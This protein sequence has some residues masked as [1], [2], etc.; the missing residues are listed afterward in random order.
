MSATTTDTPKLGIAIDYDGWRRLLRE[1]I[2]EVA[3]PDADFKVTME[4]TVET[5]LQRLKKKREAAEADDNNILTFRIEKGAG[6]GH[7]KE[8]GKI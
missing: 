7:Q 6:N 2:D 1:F 8:S 5:W 4:W 3:G